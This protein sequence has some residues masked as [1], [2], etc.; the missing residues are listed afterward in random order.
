MAALIFAQQ[1][2]AAAP[3]WALALALVAGNLVGIGLIW[4]RRRRR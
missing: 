2:P 3:T 1:Q 4:W